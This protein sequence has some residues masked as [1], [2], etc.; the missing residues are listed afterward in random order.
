[1]KKIVSGICILLVICILFIEPSVAYASNHKVSVN[2]SY[3]F[4]VIG[5][6][7]KIVYV[8]PSTGYFYYTVKIT[9]HIYD[10]EDMYDNEGLSCDTKIIVND[11]VYEST[12]LLCNEE[13]K[14]KCYTFKRGTKINI[15]IN[16]N[17]FG[18]D[19]PF[20]KMNICVNTPDNYE[21]EDN[22]NR[23]HANSFELNKIYNGLYQEED[24]DYWVFTAPRDGKYAI[25]AKTETGNQSIN[26]KTSSKKSIRCKEEEGW[27]TLFK[28][29]LKKNQKIYIKFNNGTDNLF[30]KIKAMRKK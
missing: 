21:K 15:F 11:K 19:N 18:D 9:K 22:N 28:G 7:K 8:M 20:V 3:N 23:E 4:S 29:K 24:V 26:I 6:K 16:N 14:S 25:Y 2:N 27:K 10:N 17:N 13:Y 30:Y 1:M 12:D 5:E